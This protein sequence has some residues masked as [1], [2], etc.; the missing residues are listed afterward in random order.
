MSKNEHNQGDFCFLIMNYGYQYL[1]DN[2]N[3][4]ESDNRMKCKNCMRQCHRIYDLCQG[5]IVFK[6]NY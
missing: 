2:T 3:S 4:T 1:S 5:E 6:Q